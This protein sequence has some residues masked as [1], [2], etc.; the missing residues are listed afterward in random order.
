LLRSKDSH[1]LKGWKLEG[2]ND[3]QSW[4]FI[5]EKRNQDCLSSQF[6]EVIFPCLTSNA[7][8]YFKF[9]FLDPIC[10]SSHELCRRITYFEFAG[11]ILNK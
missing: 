8:S 9:T 10:D 2:S 11:I 6:K 5:D 1:Y 3:G 4:N 7:F